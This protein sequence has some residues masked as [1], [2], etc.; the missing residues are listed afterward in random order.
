MGLRLAYIPE[1]HTSADL[2]GISQISLF[3][4]LMKAL[5]RTHGMF[6]DV[7]VPRTKEFFHWPRDLFPPEVFRE[8]P[9][10]H[11]RLPTYKGHPP[12]PVEIIEYLEDHWCYDAVV[13]NKYEHSAAIDMALAGGVGRFAETL[14]RPIVTIMSETGADEKS[15]YLR[16]NGGMF[17]VLA[18][19]MVGPCLFRTE[20]EKRYV[21]GAASRLAAANRAVAQANACVVY[22]AVDFAAIDARRGC[23]AAQRAARRAAGQCVLF[24]GGSFEGKRHLPDAVKAVEKARIVGQAMTLLLSTQKEVGGRHPF[25]E[26]FVTVREGV[27]RQ[28]FL[29]MLGDG[30]ILWYASDYESTGL[31]FH[32]GVRSG[33]PAVVYR[34]DWVRERIPS[35]YPYMVANAEGAANAVLH[36]ATHPDEAAAAVAALQAFQGDRWSA[37]A[38][39]DMFQ[40]QVGAHLQRFRAE[41]IKKVTG[42]FWT[43]FLRAGELGDRVTLDEAHRVMAAASREKKKLSFLTDHAVRTAMFAL[44]FDDAC[45][46]P[47]LTFVRKGS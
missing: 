19:C 32:E 13:N 11:D 29:E 22:P 4:D 25:K 46:G 15:T 41:N 28:A 45:E 27:G 9:L 35:D 20:F 43:D 10:H 3:S 2:S 14:D 1:F 39:A 30:D 18:S 37:G 17:S 5:H 24:H 12:I 23:Y 42:Q 33:M 44:G 36:I 7:F 40:S 34:S 16:T 38:C 6:C 47:E 21:L 8:I 31:A 26:S